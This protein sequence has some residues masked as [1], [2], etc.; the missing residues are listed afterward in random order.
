MIIPPQKLLHLGFNRENLDC[1]GLKLTLAD[2]YTTSS[3]GVL[4]V[5]K[6]IL[7]RYEKL[8]ADS[9]GYFHLN[10]GSYV[11]RYNEYVK[12]P[13]NAIA[14]AIP[15]SS[16]L[17]MGATLF[18]AVWDPGYEGRGYGLLLVENPYGVK[19]QKGVQVAQLVFMRMEEESV[20]LYRGIY[21]GEK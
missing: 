12:I 15:R 7:P 9:K 6:R 10:K 13:C 21:Y 8:E 17:R 20:K 1:S 18:T 19:L 2:V 5:D 14:L 11:I 3:Y 16:L 4:G